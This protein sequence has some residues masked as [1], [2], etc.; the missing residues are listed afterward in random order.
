MKKALGYFR[1]ALGS[2]ATKMGVVLLA[3]ASMTAIVAIVALSVFNN[4]K[5][6][7]NALVNDR[8]PEV[9]VTST[10]L[11]EANTL[12]T[13][14][15]AMRLATNEADLAQEYAI[16]SA[17][18][19]ELATMSRL[20]TSS[21]IVALADQLPDVRTALDK[22]NTSRTA[23]IQ[24]IAAL[25]SQVTAL[26][27]IAQS[28]TK[29]VD[30]E[31]SVA[32]S[33]LRI[34]SKNTLDDVENSIRQL[35]NGDVL[36]MQ[37][38]YQAEAQIN[39]LAG[40]SLA[41][42][43]TSDAALFEELKAALSRK[44]PNLIETI[45]EI[46]TS[47]ASS[48][49]PEVLDRAVVLFQKMSTING[50]MAVYQRS[51]VSSEQSALE[52]SLSAAA[53]E[54]TAQMNKGMG[55]ALAHN[56]NAINALL[57]ND[58]ASANTLHQL[59]SNMERFVAAVL[60]VTAATD[61]ENAL[62]LQ[63]EVS[64]LRGK[65]LLLSSKVGKLDFPTAKNIQSDLATLLKFGDPKTGL[66]KETLLAI[67]TRTA[68]AGATDKL[69][70]ITTELLST[71]RIAG[72]EIIQDISTDAG[73]LKDETVRAA[74]DMLKM[75]ALSAGLFVIAL[76]LTYRWIL[77]PIQKVTATTK[78]LSQGD[79]NAVTGFDKAGGE[80]RSMAMALSVF[81]DSLLD[82]KKQAEEEIKRQERE[83]Q[84][85]Q[86]RA[87]EEREAAE[88][89]AELTRKAEEERQRQQDLVR[90]ER[91]KARAKSEAEAQRLAQEQDVIVGNL[92][93]GLKSLAAG[94][95]SV[96]INT[97]FADA[98]EPLRLDFNHTVLRLQEVVAQIAD[99]EAAINQS[100][101]EINTRAD[102]LASRAVRAADTL[103]ST[104]TSLGQMAVQAQSTSDRADTALDQVEDARECSNIGRSVVAET[105]EAMH[106]IEEFSKR[107]S[108]VTNVIDDIAFQ[109]NL[110]AL[111]AGVEA[112]RAGDAGR[113]FAVVASEVRDLAQ[114]SS[115]SAGEISAL[116]KD[117][118]KKVEE[119]S[120]LVGETRSALER[121]DTAVTN[122]A[123]EA[124]E[125]ATASTDQ[126]AQIQTINQAMADLDELTKQNATLSQDMQSLNQ[127][128]VSK[129]HALAEAVSGF[130]LSDTKDKAIEN[131]AA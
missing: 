41:I 90:E 115:A 23:E 34:R 45:A 47:E 10:V 101:S 30:Q 53:A 20:S 93:S 62:L 123:V 19:D 86:L 43:Q 122:L 89:E 103:V 66:S 12:E 79:L 25:N 68:S 28:I 124:G 108:Q 114:R 107:V 55:R 38:V 121:I 48:I 116:I 15:L 83:K 87:R 128:M 67:E 6:N 16:A 17:A 118:S 39:H 52:E 102:Q 84:A 40:L 26:G 104:A 37:M 49:D 130:S 57:D 69:R 24:G 113:G 22:V 3:L 7:L 61:G 5:E 63:K 29:R 75:S 33:A 100:C 126:A 120:R 76:F 21:S 112:A 106:H 2:I 70:T 92:A 129:S 56:K 35:M 44:L 9:W 8:L 111:N 31:L 109:T 81:R 74:D 85:I 71:A 32:D 4:T 91:E 46:R 65:L 119:G 105:V 94:D 11:S 73:T 14:V 77:N 18:I 117:S 110:L 96:Q 13:S 59:E 88:R 99:S 127:T 78:R 80:I 98:Y 97:R 1:N 51:E 50:F 131:D 125:I 27:E 60:R 42:T 36:T 58:V 64:R 82:N 54:I 95:L 72:E